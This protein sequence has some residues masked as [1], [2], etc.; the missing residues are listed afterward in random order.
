MSVYCLVRTWKVRLPADGATTNCQGRTCGKPFQADSSC[1][2]VVHEERF[3][4]DPSDPTSRA[5][6]CADCVTGMGENCRK[7]V[8][9]EPM[10]GPPE[11]FMHRGKPVPFF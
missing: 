5:Y 11:P 10:F 3:R 9:P 1:S 2:M 6:L 7:I 4:I 8:L